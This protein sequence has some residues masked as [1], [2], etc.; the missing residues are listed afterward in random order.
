MT[1]ITNHYDLI[2]LGA[3]IA[4]LVAAALVARRGRRVLV[5]PHGSPEGAYRVGGR[6]FP[7]ASDPLVHIRTPPVQRVFTE[8]GLAQQVRRQHAPLRHLIHAILPDHR[9]DLAPNGSNLLQ[10]AQREWPSDA[11]EQ[12]WDCAHHWYQAT[13]SVLQELLASDNALAADGFWARRL[14]NRVAAQLPGDDVDELD[15]L[16]PGHPLRQAARATEPWVQHLGAAQLGKAARLR[17]AGLW[18]QGPEDFERGHGQLRE[19]LLQRISLHSG[20]VK[21]DLRVGELMTR[22]GRVVGVTLLG[23]R[24]RYGCDHM[25]VAT[26]PRRLLEGPLPPEAVPKGLTT[27]LANIETVA[28][29]FVLHVEINQRGVSPALDAMAFV[30]PQVPPEASEDPSV[31]SMFLRVTPGTREDTRCL[32]I[33][34]IVAPTEALG[35]MRERI[36]NELD[37]R[38]V[39]PFC[40]PYIETLHSPH[41]GRP[42][43]CKGDGTTTPQP[44]GSTLPM[45]GLYAMRHGTPSLGVGILPH[46]SDL[47]AMYFACR[48]NLPGLGLEGEF[49]AGTMA[50]GLVA[51]PGRS[52]FSRSPLLRRA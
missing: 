26:D 13:D 41:D 8:L 23:K 14:L 22:R 33:T 17:I 5:I 4:G 40:Q 31:G 46:A 19:L 9:L 39:L 7:L 44:V 3:D 32:A 50:A 34:R 29:R 49:A 30:L 21:R 43:T 10:E 6:Q 35:N 15:P 38:G 18:A 1:S 47:K 11:L 37:E 16:G 25:I 42:L 24:D 48:L 20:D 12:A 51:N 45:E 27:S 52:P 36:V 28:K 2:V